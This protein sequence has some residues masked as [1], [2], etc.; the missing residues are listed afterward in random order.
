M[1][2]L[3]FAQHSLH[4]KRSIHVTVSHQGIEATTLIDCGATENFINISFMRKRGLKPEVLQ[5]PR[6]FRLGEG[7]TSVTHSFQIEMEVVGNKYL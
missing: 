2:A 3:A 6:T 4:N 7:V 1:S 5:T